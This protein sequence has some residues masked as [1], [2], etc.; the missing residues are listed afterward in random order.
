VSTK[1]GSNLT[2]SLSSDIQSGLD[3]LNLNMSV[4]EMRQLL[5]SRKKNDPKKA[6]LDLK[7]KYNILQHM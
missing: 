6:Q 5:A 7:T 4:S 2:A 1:S 3:E